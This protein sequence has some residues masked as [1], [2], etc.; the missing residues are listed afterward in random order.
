MYELKQDLSI[1][2]QELYLYQRL[3]NGHKK[4]LNK[5]QSYLDWPSKDFAVFAVIY[6]QG[7]DV[8]KQVDGGPLAILN[9]ELLT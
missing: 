6:G 4:Q 1:P 3:Y 7:V 2:A 5:I 9:C 8:I